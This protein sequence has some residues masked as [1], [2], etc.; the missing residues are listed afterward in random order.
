M[1]GGGAATGQQQRPA[2][3]SGKVAWDAYRMQYEL[4]A[5]MNRWSDAAYLAISLRGPAT[6]VLTNLPPG[7]SFWVVTPD[8]AQP[9][10]VES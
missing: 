10:A 6:T 9:D 1:Q 8:R 7:H 4:L 5:M 3:F 2:P